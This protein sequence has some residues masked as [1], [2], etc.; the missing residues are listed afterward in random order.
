V[1]TAAP[2][3]GQA[4][5]ALRRVLAALAA[6][7]PQYG[8]LLLQP[9]PELVEAELLE[10]V[11]ATERRVVDLVLRGQAA[12]DFRVDLTA[13]WVLTAATWLVAGAADGL[14]LG[15]LASRDVEQLITGTV[16]GALRPEG[17]RR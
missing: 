14:R 2:E 10:R 15:V 8:L 9:L 4:P 12:G 13:A 5:E 6:L 1:D 17:P 16:L 3:E 11:E 7:A